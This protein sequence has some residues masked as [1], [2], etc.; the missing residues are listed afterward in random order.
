M[1]SYE[2]IQLDM[3]AEV[4]RRIDDR[5]I[6]END[7]RK[8]IEHAEQSG[9]RLKNNDTGQYRAYYRSENVT[10]WVDYTPGDGLFTVHNAYCHRMNIVGVMK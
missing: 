1:E 3:A 5:R 10:F 9:Q 8:V 4:Q 6:L 2:N 7:I